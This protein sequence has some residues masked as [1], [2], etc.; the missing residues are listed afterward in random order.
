MRLTGRAHVASVPCRSASS[1]REHEV[2]V[3]VQTSTFCYRLSGS[4]AVDD[5]ESPISSLSGKLG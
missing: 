3:V 4:F 5:R 1:A 2:F